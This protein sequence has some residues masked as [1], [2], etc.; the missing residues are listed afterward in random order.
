M[1]CIHR[2]YFIIIKQF[3]CYIFSALIYSLPRIAFQPYFFCFTYFCMTKI[4]YT[5]FLP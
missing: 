3:K 4:C 1:D 5:C 2:W